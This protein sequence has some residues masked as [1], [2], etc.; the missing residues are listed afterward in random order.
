MNQSALTCVG[1]NGNGGIADSFNGAALSPTAVALQLTRTIV[2]GAAPTLAL[3]G[4]G[5]VSMTGGI[6]QPNHAFSTLLHARRN[7]PQRAWR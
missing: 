4:N 7:D 6:R 2:F 1:S 5:T 3:G